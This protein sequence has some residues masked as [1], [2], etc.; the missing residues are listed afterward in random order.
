MRCRHDTSRREQSRG[1]PAWT[2]ICPAMPGY[3]SAFSRGLIL[4]AGAALL[5]AAARETI[6]PARSRALESRDANQRAEERSRLIDWELAT[7][8]AVRTSGRTLSLHPG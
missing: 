6:A 7:R 1:A 4:G 5:Y 3:G 2:R 8:V